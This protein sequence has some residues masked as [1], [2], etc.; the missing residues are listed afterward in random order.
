MG[1]SPSELSTRRCVWSQFLCFLSVQAETISVDFVWEPV[2]T[3]GWMFQVIPHMQRQDVRY[4]GDVQM[5]RKHTRQENFV[6]LRSVLKFLEVITGI[7]IQGHTVSLH[8]AIRA[9]TEIWT[10][11]HH[12]WHQKWPSRVS[13]RAPLLQTPGTE[14]C[15]VDMHSF[16]F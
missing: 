3:R 12:S 5:Q 15:R 14:S 8:K 6:S 4:L 1:V 7:G 11:L 13:C 9:V 16:R 2:K 10:G